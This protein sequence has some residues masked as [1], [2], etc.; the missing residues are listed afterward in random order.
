MVVLTDVTVASVAAL[1]L[2]APVR[3]GRFHGCA[4]SC[5][6]DAP[7]GCG[8]GV[9]T[10]AGALCLRSLLFSGTDLEVCGV[11]F[12][13]GFRRPDVCRGL[14]VCGVLLVSFYIVSY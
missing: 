7:D 5:L 11:L 9:G 3:I 6:G 14:E 2:L 10:E 13:C 4:L 1:L 8:R 12:R